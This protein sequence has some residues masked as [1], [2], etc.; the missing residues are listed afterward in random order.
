MKHRPPKRE[1]DVFVAM[2][3]KRFPMLFDFLEPAVY[4]VETLLVRQVEHD[5]DAV[6]PLVVRLR[7]CPVPLLPRRVPNLQAHRALIYLQ[8]PKPEIDSDRRH[9][10]LLELVILLSRENKQFNKFMQIWLLSVFHRDGCSPVHTVIT[11]NRTF[12]ALSIL[13]LENEE[14]VCHE[15]VEPFSWA[16]KNARKM[17]KLH[18]ATYREPDE[19]ARLAAT[20]I[21]DQHK[22]EEEIVVRLHVL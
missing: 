4:V 6:G 2:C 14:L 3:F 12:F 16:A 8:R 19:E 13:A 9:I 22:F 10:V 17:V 21:A 20:S 5:Q 15:R 7:Y 11:S 1:L 18:E